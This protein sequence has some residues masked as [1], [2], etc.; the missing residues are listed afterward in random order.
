M[1]TKIGRDADET[2]RISGTLEV[3]RFSVGNLHG[4]LLFREIDEV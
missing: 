3:L 4:F 1:A 2:K